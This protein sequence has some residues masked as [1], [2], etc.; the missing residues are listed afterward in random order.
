M[1]DLDASSSVLAH[2]I[3]DLEAR[4][5]RRAAGAP[6]EPD[7]RGAD[8]E[9]VA[10]AH[11]GW[12]SRIVDEHRSV[13]VFGELLALLGRLGA[14]HDATVAVHR[15]IGDELR[16]V[17]LCARLASSFGS[18]DAL[19]IDLADLALPATDEPPAARALAIV[20][21]ELVIGEGESIAVLRAYRDAAEDPAC[22]AALAELLEDEARHHA[23]GKR[24]L[25]RLIPVLPAADLAPLQRA[26]PALLREDAR[27][28]RDAHRRAATGGPGRRYGVSIRADEVPPWIEPVPE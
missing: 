7:L 25:E 19:E 8:G 23:I 3:A 15:V 5:P 22:R 13:I 20:A 14:P 12:A 6:R 26:L 9:D 11:L 1:I 2:A 16:H 4:A 18:L 24:L 10:A 17:R 21:R 28:I 27:E